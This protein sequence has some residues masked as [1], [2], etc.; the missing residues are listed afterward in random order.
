MSEDNLSEE[1]LLKE[2]ANSTPPTLGEGA[3][4][5]RQRAHLL[6][7]WSEQ[8]QDLRS[9]ASTLTVAFRGLESWQHELEAQ[10]KLAQ[11]S[12]SREEKDRIIREYDDALMAKIEAAAAPHLARWKNLLRHSW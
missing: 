5:W 7:C 1:M 10:Q 8:N 12:M 3:A 9:A 2:L 4:I 6:W 11:T